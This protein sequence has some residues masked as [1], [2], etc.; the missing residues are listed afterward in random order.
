MK[1]KSFM[2]LLFAWSALTISITSCGKENISN[3]VGDDLLV[4]QLNIAGEIDEGI[5]ASASG[6]ETRDYEVIPVDSLPTSILDYVAA[7]YPDSVTI[8]K[9]I[10]THSGKYVVGLS[11]GIVLVFDANGNFVKILPK[12][13]KKKHGHGHGNGHGHGQDSTGHGHGQDSTGHGHGQDSTGHGHGHGQDST[14]HGHGHGQDSTGQGHGH[15]QD[16]TGHNGGHHGGKGKDL[17]PLDITNLPAAISTYFADQ[18]PTAEIKKAA[19]QNNTGN[20]LVFVKIDDLKYLFIFD[21]QG[22]FISKKQL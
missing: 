3:L 8:V 21:S 5:L 1:L 15:G 9:A 19:T 4:E 7:N 20:Y 10:L 17:T 16:S 22:V 12:K 2:F 6:I 14:G 13:W 18:Y 11:N